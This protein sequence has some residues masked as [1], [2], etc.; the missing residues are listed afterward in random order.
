MESCASTV[1]GISL[2]LCVTKYTPTPRERISFTVCSTFCSSTAG[3]SRNS[4][5]ASSKKNTIRGLS[6]SPASGR[7]SNSSDSIHSRKLAYLS[8]I[9]I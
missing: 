6:R 4:M 7:I 3:A 1:S 8:L 2:G 5:W 9:H